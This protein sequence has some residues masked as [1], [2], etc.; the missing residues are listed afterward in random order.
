MNSIHFAGQDFMLT[1]EELDDDLLDALKDCGT[2]GE[3]MPQV[4][5]VLDNFTITGDRNDCR[6]YLRQYGAWANDDELADHDANLQR[7]IWLVGGDLQFEGEMVH[8]STY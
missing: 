8:F 6:E 3:S 4:Q 5:Y 2:P 7:L 1:P